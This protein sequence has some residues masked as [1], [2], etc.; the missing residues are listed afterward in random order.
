MTFSPNRTLEDATQPDETENS[1]AD[2]TVQGDS[3]AALPGSGNVSF[4]LATPRKEEQTTLSNTSIPETQS[5]PMDVSV[6]AAQTE[7]PQKS[8]TLP[9]TPTSISRDY[10]REYHS[11]FWCSLPTTPQIPPQIATSPVVQ[12]QPTPQSN[13][14]STTEP[15]KISIAPQSATTGTAPLPLPLSSAALALAGTGAGAVLY[16]TP[17]MSTRPVPSIQLKFAQSTPLTS[18][19]HLPGAGPISSI[20]VP[21]PRLATATPQQIVVATPKSGMVFPSATGTTP[22]M[23]V[24]TGGGGG[25]AITSGTTPGGGG[26]AFNTTEAVELQQRNQLLGALLNQCHLEVRADLDLGVPAR[27]RVGAED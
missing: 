26:G 6:P 24:S 27:P 11:I 13:I 3:E 20:Q 1:S 15:A 19:P 21:G 16:T 25:L 7:T 17:S 14:S 12:N 8:T 9:G 2:Q 10:S 23:G 4:S 18:P 22:M 5:P